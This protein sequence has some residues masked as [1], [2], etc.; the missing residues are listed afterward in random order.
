MTQIQTILD[1]IAYFEIDSKFYQQSIF[2][3]K[4]AQFRIF[5]FLAACLDGRWTIFET[6]SLITSRSNL[7]S[8]LIIK[9]VYIYMQDHVQN[10][11]DFVSELRFHDLELDM[12]E[13]TQFQ[14]I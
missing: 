9:F 14:L 4:I 13:I 7:R 5:D 3:L 10:A 6:N 12:F 11:A 1:T 2:D 8:W